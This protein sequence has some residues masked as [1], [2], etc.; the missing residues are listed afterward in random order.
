MKYRSSAGQIQT[1]VLIFAGIVGLSVL[2]FFLFSAGSIR[3]AGQR[4]AESAATPRDP[5]GQAPAAPAIPGSNLPPKP[6]PLP[7]TAP[8]FHANATSLL[9]ALG[10]AL[11]EKNLEQAMTLAGPSGT[12]PRAEFVRHLL[13]SAGFT[14]PAEGPV[15]RET[16]A[17]SGG[18]RHE[19]QLVP[20]APGGPEPLGSV[21]VDA[22]RSATGPAWEVRGWRFS[23]A[24]VSQALALIRQ[25]GVNLSPDAL[26]TPPDALSQAHDF[27]TE[28]LGRDF[29]RRL[30]IESE[31][32]PNH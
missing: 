7:K 2:F 23:P 1:P 18:S 12:G 32:A 13:T 11:R 30:S 9:D 26:A 15:F 21:M 8:A 31:Q 6:A 10:T 28:A 16:G 19:L 5:S 17:V 29:R 25:Q 27:L 20:S 3:D 14:V 22:G 4:A 24:L